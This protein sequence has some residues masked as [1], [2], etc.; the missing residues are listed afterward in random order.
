M[1]VRHKQLKAFEAA[2]TPLSPLDR[3]T[4]SSPATRIPQPWA[5]GILTPER[6]LADEVKSSLQLCLP[7]R[8]LLCFY[9]AEAPVIQLCAASRQSSSMPKLP[10]QCLL[11]SCCV[12]STP[13][14]CYT[15]LTAPALLLQSAVR[16]PTGRPPLASSARGQSPGVPLPLV[17][18]YSPPCFDVVHLVH[19]MGCAADAADIV[20]ELD[21]VP[22]LS[23][24]YIPGGTG[25]VPCLVVAGLQP[26]QIVKLLV[27]LA[28][29]L[30]GP[31]EEDL[32]RAAAQLEQVLDAFSD[33]A[34][35][36]LLDGSKA[37]G[38][39]CKG[40]GPGAMR[41]QGAFSTPP[42]SRLQ[43]S[44]AAWWLPVR[45]R[46]ERFGSIPACAASRLHAVVQGVLCQSP[47]LCRG[48]HMTP[49]RA[50]HALGPDTPSAPL[51]QVTSP[52]IPSPLLSDSAP[53]E[54]DTSSALKEFI[55][56]RSPATPGAAYA[57][58][59]LGVPTVRQ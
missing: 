58:S 15:G 47:N 36:C 1:Q 51:L 41:Q 26:L 31:T 23:V 59:T 25:L 19:S 12:Q 10:P 2:R 16:S 56:N 43:V 37:P 13:M 20:A 22:G 52:A 46:G 18:R 3:H 4:N 17:G 50:Q 11:H 14:S 34:K 39:S 45:G 9:L 42:R 54:L 8:S 29:Q 7:L 48:Q 28:P 38:V 5:T 35:F 27:Q 44:R 33:P 32:Q 24:E 49:S 6:L 55:N 30:C 57:R 21:Y 40:Q 53:A